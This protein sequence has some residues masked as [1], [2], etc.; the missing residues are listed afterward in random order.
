MSRLGSPCYQGKR[1]REERGT[2]R[3][4]EGGPDIDE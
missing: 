3:E 2:S 1:V 4:G